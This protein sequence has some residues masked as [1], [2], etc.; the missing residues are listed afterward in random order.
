[1]IRTFVFFSFL[2]EINCSL[3]WNPS[4]HKILCMFAQ[5]EALHL[6]TPFSVCG[7][8]LNRHDCMLPA[9]SHLF[10]LCVAVCDAT[11]CLNP[12][13]ICPSWFRQM[14]SVVCSNIDSKGITPV[15]SLCKYYI[16]FFALSSPLLLLLQSMCPKQDV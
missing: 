11:V 16:P 13:L 15:S 4:F 10:C 1:M 2:G 14:L 5:W 6:S 12:P 7:F 9:C 3:A 8:L